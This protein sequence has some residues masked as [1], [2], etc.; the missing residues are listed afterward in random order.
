[1][2]APSKTGPPCPTSYTTS[3]MERLEVIAA[4]QEFV[5]AYLRLLRVNK[6]AAETVYKD[7]RRWELQPIKTVAEL[8]VLRNRTMD[9]LNM[10]FK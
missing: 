10:E 7:Y 6:A 3:E 1:M 9:L 5:S 8:D 4:R 2:H